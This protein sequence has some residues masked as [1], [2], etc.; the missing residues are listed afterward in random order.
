MQMTH[1]SSIAGTDG[2]FGNTGGG[3]WNYPKGGNTVWS[4]QN[5]VPVSPVVN[6]VV[7]PSTGGN[8]VVWSWNEPTANLDLAASTV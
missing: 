2:Q 7:P 4:G 1:L 5:T 3:N 8:E 6:N